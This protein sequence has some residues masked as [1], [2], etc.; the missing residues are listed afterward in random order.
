MVTL[1]TGIMFLIFTCM[2]YWCGEFYDG[3]SRVR[4]PAMK[5]SAAAESFRNT[6]LEKQDMK[7]CAGFSWLKLETSDWL[8]CAL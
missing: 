1:A 3:G 2:H 4:R 7:L 5:W 8:L 6:V